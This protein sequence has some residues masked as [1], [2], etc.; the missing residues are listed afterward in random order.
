MGPGITMYFKTVRMLSFLMI[1]FTIL[2]IPLFTIYSK[3]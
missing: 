1:V 2:Y 3:N